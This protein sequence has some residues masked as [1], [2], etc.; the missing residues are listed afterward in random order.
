MPW[1][2][3]LKWFKGLRYFCFQGLWALG[4]EF[5]RFSKIFGS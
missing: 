3:G 1:G 5:R 4:V 2:L